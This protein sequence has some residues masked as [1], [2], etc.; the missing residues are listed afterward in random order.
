MQSDILG[1]LKDS[2]KKLVKYESQSGGYT[3]FGY[4]VGWDNMTAFGLR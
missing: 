2:Y 4:G 1:T 3:W